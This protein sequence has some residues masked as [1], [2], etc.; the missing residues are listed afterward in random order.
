MHSLG[1]VVFVSDLMSYLTVL[2]YF[3]I[4]F[5]V[6]CLQFK[7][8]KNHTKFNK[9]I[10]KKLTKTWDTFHCCLHDHELVYFLLQSFS[11]KIEPFVV[12]KSNMN[13]YLIFFWT[14]KLFMS[15]TTLLFDVEFFAIDIVLR[16]HKIT[17]IL[18]KNTFVICSI[19]CFD[20]Q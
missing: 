11:T 19:N 20:F 16:F 5:K 13:K 10:H 15:I 14:R 4:F 9:E 12:Y 2:Y 6:K 3:V 1:V 17:P 7:L 8:E 18:P